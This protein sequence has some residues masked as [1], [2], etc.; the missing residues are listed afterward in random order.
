M[1]ARTS[2]DPAITRFVSAA[3]P[4]RRPGLRAFLLR[5]ETGR[6][7]QLRVAVKSL[8]SPVLGDERYGQAD[9]ARLE[10][11][12]YLHCAAMR[13]RTLGGLVQVRGQL[14][15]LRCLDCRLERQLYNVLLGMVGG[16]GGG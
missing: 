14:A 8:G 6:T 13:F 16:G 9:R 12:G 11:R 4:G 5:P 1:L 3:V 7:H 10:A 15:L 2:A